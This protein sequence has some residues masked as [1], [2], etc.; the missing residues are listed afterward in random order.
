[1]LPEATPQFARLAVN[2]WGIDSDGKSEEELAT[3]FLDSLTAFIKEAGLPETFSEM[4]ISQ[5]TD[6]KAV[7]DS[8]V[9]TGGCCKKFTKE[10]LLEV[11]DQCK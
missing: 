6:Y 4:G 1:M 9:L 7:A 2:V 10:E 11:L 3:A 8:A 5:D